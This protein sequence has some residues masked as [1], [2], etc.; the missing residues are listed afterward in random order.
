M[1]KV[2]IFG[3]EYSYVLKEERGLPK[4]EQTIWWYKLPDLETQCLIAEAIEFEGDPGQAE[5]M[6]TVFR[7]D[8]RAEAEVIRR[9]LVRVENLR[10]ESGRAVE[11]PKE[12]AAQDE[13]LAVLLPAWRAELAA[14]F[15]A[16]G[17]LTEDEAKNS[18]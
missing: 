8:R 3:K 18:A 15:R 4:E 14:A 1:A 16:A 7:P 13:F 10:D 6:R 9:C 17:R 11:W 5:G 2:R 12:K